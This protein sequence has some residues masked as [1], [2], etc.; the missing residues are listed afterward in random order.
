[1]GAHVLDDAEHGHCDLL[2][3]PEALA[4]IEQRDVLRRRDDD[5]AAHGHALRQRELDVP[6]AGRHVHDEVVE[7][8]PVGIGQQLRQRLRDHGTAPDH[9]LLLLDEEADRHDLD[10]VRDERLHALAVGRRGTLALQPEHAGLA[11]TVY[12]GVQQPDARTVEG[13]RER[14]VHRGRGLANAPLAR[15]DRDD[16]RDPR[17]R[18]QAALDSVAGHSPAHA[19]TAVTHLRRGIQHFLQDCLEFG[20]CPPQREAQL[21]LHQHLAALQPDGLHSFGVRQGHPEVGFDII[22]DHEVGCSSAF[23]RHRGSTGEKVEA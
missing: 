21:D 13:E 9:R 15:G 10:A 16:V 6:G 8:A 7:V 14:E 17:Q 23:V 5:R 20:P 3:H 1:M 2:E 22:P 4:C 11:W 19:D 18:L 12:V